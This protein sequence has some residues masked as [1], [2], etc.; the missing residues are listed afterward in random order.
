MIA[1]TDAGIE[2]FGRGVEKGVDVLI[3]VVDPSQEPILL[4]SKISELGRQ[5]EKPVY[6]VLNR[7]SNQE[8]RDLLMDAMDDKARV[9]GYIPENKEIFMSGLTGSEFSMDVEGVRQVADFLE[10]LRGVQSKA[11]KGK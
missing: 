11:A 9:I 5:V 3:V 2:H 7:V 1:D 6:Y 4:A 8:T 10:S